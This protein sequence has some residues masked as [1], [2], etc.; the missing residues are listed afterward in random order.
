MAAALRELSGCS[1][2]RQVAMPSLWRD[3]RRKCPSENV[4]AAAGYLSQDVCGRKAGNHGLAER[5]VAHAEV[6]H[7]WERRW[8]GPW[9]EQADPL[10]PHVTSYV[11]WA[12]LAL[13]GS[14]GMPCP[15]Q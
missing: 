10:P 13:S 1:G 8:A 2:G 9:E 6:P 4:R 5:S 12:G 15:S 11:T 3:L 14:Q 7:H